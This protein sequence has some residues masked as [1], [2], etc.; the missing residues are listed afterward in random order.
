M[1]KISLFLMTA[2][3]EYSWLAGL[4]AMILIHSRGYTLPLY[5]SLLIF[6]LAVVLT[7]ISRSRGW[8]VIQVLL[9][10]IMGIAFVLFISLQN[11]YNNSPQ[12]PEE[13]FYLIVVIIS[14][15]ILW[16]G[17]V[18]LARRSYNYNLVSERF[19]KGIGILAFVIFT[20]E[21]AIKESSGILF[22]LALYFIFSILAIGIA[23]G[24]GEGKKEYISG[25]GKIG[26]IIG[27]VLIATLVVIT[28]FL[29]GFPYLTGVADAGYGVIKS[30]S[31]PF[32]PLLIRILR[33][34]YG[35][36]VAVNSDSYSSPDIGEAIATETK[37]N[38]FLSLLEKIAGP[39]LI[40]IL[41]I[42]GVVLG[43]FLLR[44]LI[45]LLFSRTDRK[46]SGLNLKDYLYRLYSTI[47][48]ILAGLITRDNRNIVIKIYHK[49]CRW[50]RIGGLGKLP[51]ETANEY[52]RRLRD[53]FPF[54]SREIEI[55]IDLFNRDIYSRKPVTS[56]EI[57]RAEIS[58]KKISSPGNWIYLI[59][60]NFNEKGK[61]EN[62]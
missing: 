23:R 53:K 22:W 33:A 35:R 61:K 6:G 2:G 43:F 1:M 37:S 56:E 54:L 24:A 49:L 26:L 51:T 47:R 42:M 46:H 3:M 5:E 19:D 52:S 58:W 50:G 39:L 30:I 10:Q 31:R 48:K 28:I 7:Y 13:W 41:I 38:W 59:K 20:E 14:I 12:E 55:I 29:S 4:T 11:Y 9:L 16:S 32:L 44:Y 17:G 57:T 18:S 8:L 62:Y 34:L 45:H 60:L 21:V 40:V 36:G 27:F 15:L 25:Y